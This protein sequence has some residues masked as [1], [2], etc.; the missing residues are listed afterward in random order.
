[1]CT[2]WVTPCLLW[3]LIV[4]FCPLSTYLISG[5]MTNRPA[6]SFFL[7]KMA[8]FFP[9]LPNLTHRDPNS[10]KPL[11]NGALGNNFMGP[12]LFLGIKPNPP[13][14][15]SCT[16]GANFVMA[17]P[18]EPPWKKTWKMMFLHDFFAFLSQNRKTFPLPWKVL[19]C[20]K[21]CLFVYKITP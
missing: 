4:L 5:W 3:P 1:M 9:F 18:N 17:H 19:T 16:S 15:A 20:L 7:S 6:N 11:L 13:K 21:N 12:R 10:V 14:I 2:P 8:T